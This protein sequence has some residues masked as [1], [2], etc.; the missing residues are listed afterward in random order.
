MQLTLPNKTIKLYKTPTDFRRGINRL[1]SMIVDELH[2]QPNEGIYI[3][4]NRTRDKLKIL[5]WHTNG[6]LLLHKQF[7]TNK[8]KFT[9][10]NLEGCRHLTEQEFEWLLAGLD[11]QAMSAWGSL[12]FEKFS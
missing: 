11:W 12:N 7:E 10:K 1:S 4:Y 5:V 2:D 6:F 9:L 8:I 3:F